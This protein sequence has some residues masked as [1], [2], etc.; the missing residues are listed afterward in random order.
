MLLLLTQQDLLFAAQDLSGWQ[1]VF[2]TDAWSNDTGYLLLWLSGYLTQLFYT[3]WVGIC[4]LGV[5]WAMG[6]LAASWGLRLNPSMRWIVVLPVFGLVAGIAQTGYWIYTLRLPGYFVLPS[7]VFVWFSF[8]IA[9]LRVLY[10]VRQS[11]LKS[12]ASIIAILVWLYII[13]PWNGFPNWHPFDNEPEMLFRPWLFCFVASFLI[14]TVSYFRS[15]ELPMWLSFGV[16][17]LCFVATYFFSCYRNQNFTNEIKQQQA[18]E[19]ADWSSIINISKTS[20]RTPTRQMLLM[21][22]MARMHKDFHS[23][24]SITFNGNNGVKPAM[25]SDPPIHMAQM[26]GPTIYLGFGYANYAYRWAFENSVEFGF[27]PLRLR[28]L[29]YCALL[30]GEYTLAQKYIDMLS[31]FLFHKATAERLAQLVN[32]PELIAEDKLLG[33]LNLWLLK[34]DALTFDNGRPERF[35][36]RNLP[37]THRAKWNYTTPTELHIY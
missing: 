25:Y 14:L 30:Q 26:G 12:C 23:G 11:I 3:P 37:F 2:N 5:L 31:R 17:I 13:K 21:S 33:D 27:S 7:L 1:P 4:L 18:F 32:H 8:L 28:L 29:S 22:D 24:D 9:L 16:L 15:I 34:S 20:S 36:I 35:L 10:T 19:S 6:S